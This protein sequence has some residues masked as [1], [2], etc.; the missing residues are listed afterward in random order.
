MEAT[1]VGGLEEDFDGRAY[2]GLQYPRELLGRDEHEIGRV[3]LRGADRLGMTDDPDH[4]ALAL[5]PGDVRESMQHQM[6][7]AGAAR[8]VVSLI[9]G[10]QPHFMALPS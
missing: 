8:E 6:D 7:V 4:V 9:R 3:R 10:L 1:R 5:R 2:A